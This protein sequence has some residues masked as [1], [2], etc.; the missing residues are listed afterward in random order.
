MGKLENLV[1]S[2]LESFDEGLTL[3]EIA[4]KVGQSEKKVYKV[5][6]K[7]FQKGKINSENRRYKLSKS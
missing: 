4:E 6:R 7:L 2:T 5:L 1:V 3:A